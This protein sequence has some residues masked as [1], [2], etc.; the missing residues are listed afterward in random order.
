MCTSSASALTLCFF[1]SCRSFC[2]LAT[3][4][5][6]AD[7]AFDRDLRTAESEEE[8]WDKGTGWHGSPDGGG[9]VEAISR[10]QRTIAHPFRLAEALTTHRF[11][12]LMRHVHVL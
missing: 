2:N 11:I 3:A 8:G 10:R 9:E 1:S 4:I 5:C 12:Y 7:A 6:A